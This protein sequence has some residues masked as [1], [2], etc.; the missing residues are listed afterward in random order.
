MKVKIL[1]QK[2]KEVFRKTPVDTELEKYKKGVSELQNHIYNQ[3]D[4]IY[5][6][7]DH[8]HRM[9]DFINVNLTEK[10][11]ESLSNQRIH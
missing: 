6:L 10:Y 1:F 3:N 2:L 11:K 5:Y 8:V 9:N 7:E 4:Y